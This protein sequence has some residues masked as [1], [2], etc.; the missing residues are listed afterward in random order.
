MFIDP[1]DLA[2]ES[3]ILEDIEKASMRLVTQAV[4]E[5]RNEAAENFA[6]Q[7]DKPQDIAED[8]TR[9]AL[10]RLGV[11]RMDSRLPGNIDYKR[12]RYL[13]HPEY[14]IRQAL[15]VDSKAEKEDRTATLQVAQTSLRIRHIRAG[16]AVDEAGGLPPIA[17]SDKGDCVTT[18]IIVKYI[19]DDDPAPILKKAIVAA[20]PNG[21]LQEQ[22]NPTAADTIWRTGRNAPQRDEPF[23]VR[24]VF[25]RLQQKKR[26]R[27]Q[28]IDIPP[29]P[30]VPIAPIAPPSFD[31]QE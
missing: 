18:S 12:A 4:F 8:L 28:V 5:F 14:A 10:D 20:I 3:A 11:S 7:R 17:Q 21:F 6:R 23:R 30:P 16:N 26:W 9:E 15:L 24:L 2:H 29:P 1:A 13:F 19:Y 27:V 31:W 22:Y 25:Q